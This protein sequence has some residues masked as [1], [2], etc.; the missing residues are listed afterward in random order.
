MP[1]NI[2]YILNT[3]FKAKKTSLLLA[4]Q[5]FEIGVNQRRDCGCGLD[6]SYMI[7]GPDWLWSRPVWFFSQ[8]CNQTYKH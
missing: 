7:S 2:H 5:Y 4:P 6:G 8:S 3:Y 1:Q